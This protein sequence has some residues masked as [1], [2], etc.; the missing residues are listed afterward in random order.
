MYAKH[1]PA[2]GRWAREQPEHFRDV[3]RFV[4]LTIRQPLFNAVADMEALQSDNQY[5]HGDAVRSALWGFKGESWAFIN[6]N[7]ERLYHVLEDI[8]LNADC[9]L[10]MEDEMLGFLATEVPGLGLIK[11][12][13]AL[14]IVYGVSGCIDSH[15]LRRFGLPSRKFDS[16]GRLHTLKRKTLRKKCREYHDTVREHGG[17]SGLWDSWCDYV[18]KKW[19]SRYRD[20]D[21]V[22]E[23][24]AVAFML[25]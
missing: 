23:L 18:A 11:A 25:T 8:Y 3:L 9:P 20:A 10:E 2:I 7:Y 13:F 19:P 14:Q 5:E 15:N 12:G 22:S 16:K 17:T 6:T 24:H 21:H 1:Q 4:V